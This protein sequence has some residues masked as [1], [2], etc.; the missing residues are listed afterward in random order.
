MKEKRDAAKKNSKYA[1]SFLIL[2]TAIISCLAIS[3][4]NSSFRLKNITMDYSLDPNRSM[5]EPTEEEKSNFLALVDQPFAYLG[6]GNQVYAFVSSDNK[7]VLKFFKCGHLKSRFWDSWLPGWKKRDERKKRKIERIFNA[8]A[9]AY[10]L[11]R[12]HA[13]LLFAH[14][15]LTDATLPTIQVSDRLGMQ[16]DVPL[17]SV[18][19]V[20]QRKGEPLNVKMHDLLAKGHV[21]QAQALLTKI[22]GMYISEYSLGICDQDYNLWHNTG[23]AGENPIRI[24]VGKIIRDPQYAE[25]SVY[26]KDLEKVRSRIGRWLERYYPQYKEQ[27][28]KLYR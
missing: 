25:S 14:L 21:D 20:L 6:E 24:D 16:H 5:P 11:D 26:L 7:Y 18:F 9:I 27:M 22:I 23:F 17:D 15:M 4:Y 2:F 3:Y 1:R 13:G 10:Q 12:D 19:F 8:H 28:E